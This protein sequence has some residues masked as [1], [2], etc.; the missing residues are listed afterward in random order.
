MNRVVITGF[1]AISPLG[2]T[3]E[4]TW[5]GIIEGKSGVGPIVHFDPSDAP[6]TA[7]WRAALTAFSGLPMSQLMKRWNTAG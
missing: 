5:K 7:S 6:V 3:A 4:T 2:H 1:G